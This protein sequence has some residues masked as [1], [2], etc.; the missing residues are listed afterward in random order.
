MQNES[1]EL[2]DLSRAFVAAYDLAELAMSDG[3]NVHGALS[4]LVG[5]QDMLVHKALE[6]SDYPT[7]TTLGNL[8]GLSGVSFVFNETDII[9]VQSSFSGPDSDSSTYVAEDDKEY[10]FLDSTVIPVPIP[11]EGFKVR[12]MK[13]NE[14][15]E[16]RFYYNRPLRARDLLD[17]SD[18]EPEGK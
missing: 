6:L 15:V 9:E 16:M 11:E 14:L 13:T 8:Q 2:A 10:D 1:K 4:G 5:T 3:G 17:A 18:D 12:E 7:T